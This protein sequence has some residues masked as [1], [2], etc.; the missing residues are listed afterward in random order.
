MLPVMMSR[1][2]QHKGWVGGARAAKCDFSP[3]FFMERI[4]LCSLSP[5]E[6]EGLWAWIICLTW[7][8]VRIE[9]E[10]TLERQLVKR[11]D[12]K[13]LGFAQCSPPQ[14]PPGISQSW[15]CLARLVRGLR[16]ARC[17]QEQLQF[18]LGPGCPVSIPVTAPP[19]PVLWIQP[20]PAEG[21]SEIPKSVLDA[22]SIP[23][24]NPFPMLV[25]TQEQSLSA[26][27]FIHICHYRTEMNHTHTVRSSGRK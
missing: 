3:G 22:V 25:I 20:S 26:R 6:M 8:R 11:P 14:I 10:S 12:P 21:H 23:G 5:G 24:W 17:V 9:A 13:Y 15:I 27:G 16:A 4:E 1:A 19:G 7:K 18:Q 2:W